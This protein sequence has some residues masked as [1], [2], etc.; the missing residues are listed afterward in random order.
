MTP[1]TVPAPPL[2]PNQSRAPGAHEPAFST[3]D[4]R[5]WNPVGRVSN[6]AFSF[7]PKHPDGG[8]VPLAIITGTTRA[9]A[10]TGRL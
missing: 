6:K 2:A 1:E 10:A 3:C 8:D 4:L 5:E 7:I 9:G